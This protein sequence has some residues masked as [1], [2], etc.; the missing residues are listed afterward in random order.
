[1][2]WDSEKQYIS[3]L[4]RARRPKEKVW[5]VE[6]TVKGI[7]RETDEGKKYAQTKRKQRTIRLCRI[8]KEVTRRGLCKGIRKVVKVLGISEKASTSQI[9]V[10]ITKPNEERIRIEE[11][12]ANR[13]WN[14]TKNAKGTLRGSWKVE[15]KGRRIQETMRQTVRRK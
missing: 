4:V 9:R 5:T 15:V 13:G 7:T 6:V 3:S 10:V 1:M 8:Q 2:E 12:K 14:E 11:R